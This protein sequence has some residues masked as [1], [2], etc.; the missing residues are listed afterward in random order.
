MNP[1]K[2]FVYGTLKPEEVNYHLYC[3][4]KV[5]EEKKAIAYGQLFNLPLGYPAMTLGNSQ[6][7][8]YLLTF[9]H[10]GV[11]HLLD[12]LEDYQEYRSPEENEYNRQQLAIYTLVGQSLGLAWVY[13]MTP[14]QVQHHSGILLPSGSWS[15]SINNCVL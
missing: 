9:A 1:L 10:R 6:I 12:E 5:V 2:V 7:H 3:A 13:L 4:G 11:L 8:G 15:G 14:Q